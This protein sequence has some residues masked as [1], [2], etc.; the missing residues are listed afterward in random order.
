MV[1]IFFGCSMRGGYDRVSQEELDKIPDIIEELGYELASRHQ[2]QQ[3]IIEEENKRTPPFIHDR[4]YGW[5]VES[6]VGIFELSN[7]S[8]GVGGEISDMI[9]LR[10]PVLCAFKRGLEKSV[11]NYIQGK[12]GSKYVETPFE[13]YAYES[14][15]DL[16]EKIKEFVETYF[17]SK[18]LN[19]P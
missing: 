19:S 7:P 10:K 18:E 11:S 13:C 3:G 4:D 9:N 8:L 16:K 6:D 14:L 5:E 1:K 17:G 12:Q 15:E 2:T